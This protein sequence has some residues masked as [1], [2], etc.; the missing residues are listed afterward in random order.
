[1]V[2]FCIGVIVQTAAFQPSSIYGGS[3]LPTFVANLLVYL[4]QGGLLLPLYK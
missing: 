4:M 1:M 3:S 2:I